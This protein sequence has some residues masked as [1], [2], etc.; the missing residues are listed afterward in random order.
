MKKQKG[1]TRGMAVPLHFGTWLRRQRTTRGQSLRDLERLSGLSIRNLQYLEAG[2][3]RSITEETAARLAR[4]LGI[5]L[6]DFVAALSTLELSF[7]ALRRL[8][9]RVDRQLLGVVNS[10][11]GMIDPATI[12]ESQQAIISAALDRHHLP[13]RTFVEM[14]NDDLTRRRLLQ[15]EPAPAVQI[16]VEENV[17]WIEFHCD[18]GCL[19]VETPELLWDCNCD[20]L[21]NVKSKTCRIHG[22]ELGCRI[23]VLIRNRPVMIQWRGAQFMW[24]ECP[25]LW[26]PS[27]DSFQFV[28]MLEQS[29]QLDVGRW[30][31]ILDLGSG[32]GFL[33]VMIARLRATVRAAAF[34]D[35]AMTPFIF[36]ALNA[37]RNLALPRKVQV[38]ALL[39]LYT[40][41]SEP[42]RSTFDV[43]IGRAHV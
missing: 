27:I 13:F 21:T 16:H 31:T 29:G 42:S 14:M 22:T 39:G 38:S 25:E 33:G 7:E 1:A 8:A 36:S 32:T 10:H 18:S 19:R 9:F 43:E 11:L 40:D 6:S 24:E 4:A 20:L 28:R 15:A 30:N 26:P 2:H 23:A 35:W 3:S 17:E 12:A 5:T 34:G 37:A 41:W